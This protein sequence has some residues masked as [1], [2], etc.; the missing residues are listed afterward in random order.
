MC[1]VIWPRAVGLQKRKGEWSGSGRGARD[2]TLPL[3]VE[4]G[5]GACAEHG[6][7]LGATGKAAA[8]S[9]ERRRGPGTHHGAGA[10]AGVLRALVSLLAPGGPGPL[11]PPEQRQLEVGVRKEQIIEC[12][13]CS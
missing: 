9:G 12:R 10:P 11:G 2:P 6:H 7:P 1:C 4:R 5:T 13:L 8:S 3:Q